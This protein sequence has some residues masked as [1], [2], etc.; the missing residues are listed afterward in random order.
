M[1]SNPM[2]LLLQAGKLRLIRKIV[3]M[4]INGIHAFLSHYITTA[5]FEASVVR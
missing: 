3:Q 1:I 5:Y 2:L 4:P